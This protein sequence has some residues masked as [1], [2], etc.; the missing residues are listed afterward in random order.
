LKTNDK[1]TYKVPEKS[2]YKKRY[3]VR[4]QEE[5]EAEAEIK[6]YEEPQCPKYEK[7]EGSE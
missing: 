1:D 6:H 5:L 3:R 2:H 4:I 7:D